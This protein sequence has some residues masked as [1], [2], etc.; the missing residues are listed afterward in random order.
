MNS[1]TSHVMTNLTILEENKSLHSWM[2]MQ[3]HYNVD[4]V[5]CT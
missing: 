5:T 2:D 1:L 4:L 3:P